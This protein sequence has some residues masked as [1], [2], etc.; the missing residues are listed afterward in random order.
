MDVTVSGVSSVKLAICLL[1]V[2]TGALCKVRYLVHCTILL[3]CF[4]ATELP[5]LF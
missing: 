5:V 3:L 4:L 1:G 2:T